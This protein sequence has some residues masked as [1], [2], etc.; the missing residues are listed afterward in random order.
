LP[1]ERRAAALAELRQGFR[2]NIHASD[3]VEVAKLVQRASS[4]LAFLRMV[5]PTPRGEMGAGTGIYVMRDGQLRQGRA[6]AVSAARHSAYDA[7]NIDPDALARHR[8]LV[9]R[10]HFGRRS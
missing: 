7:T 8:R 10:Q 6:D 9:E 1:A 3:P 4:K 2:A 5:T